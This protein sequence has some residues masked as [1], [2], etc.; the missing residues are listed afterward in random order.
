M[1][2]AEVEARQLVADADAD[3]VGKARSARVLIVDGGDGR[4]LS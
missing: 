3:A 2:E 1:S 4:L